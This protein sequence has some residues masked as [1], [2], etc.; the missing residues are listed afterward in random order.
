[1]DVGTLIFAI[2]YVIVGTLAI[3][4][5]SAAPW[6]PTKRGQRR[7]VVEVVPL[8]DGAKVYDLG[9][10]DGGVLLD[11]AAKRP[12]IR[13]VGYE[14][15]LLPLAIG[16]VRKLVAGAA[17][18]G[19]SLR[20]RDFFGAKVGDADVVF[21]F[22]F[23]ESY[24]RVMRKLAKDL[25]DDALVVVEAWPFPNAVADRVIPREAQILPMYFYSGAAVKAA[26]A[27]A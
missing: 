16:L 21:V 8:K 12:D 13:A 20:L 11:L 10:G 3:G 27:A 6:L 22:L 23:R 18:R 19:V 9:C 14:I 26:V 25:R 2:I 1:M 15:A 17:G 5:I 24:P 4:G 7:R